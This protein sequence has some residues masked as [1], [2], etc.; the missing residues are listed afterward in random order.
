MFNLENS[1]PHSKRNTNNLCTWTTK[2]LCS[3]P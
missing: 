3:T 1:P 2:S